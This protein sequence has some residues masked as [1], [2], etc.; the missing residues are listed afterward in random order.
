MAPYPQRYHVDNQANECHLEMHPSHDLLRFSA[1]YFGK[2]GLHTSPK[3]KGDNAVHGHMGMGHIKIRKMPYEI[4]K[5]KALQTSLSG[6]DKIKY[7]TN[8]E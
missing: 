3:D 4:R 8:Q 7:N 1:C 5:P 2:Y 6:S